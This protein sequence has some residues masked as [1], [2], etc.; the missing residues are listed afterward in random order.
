M[1]KS[2]VY[3]EGVFLGLRPRSTPKGLGGTLKASVVYGF[4]GNAGVGAAQAGFDID[5][6]ICEADGFGAW[7]V[8]RN[9]HLLPGDFSITVSDPAQW[10]PAEGV[11]LQIGTPPCAAFASVNFGIR[12]S[13]HGI[14]SGHNDC[15]R[16][17]FGYA[18]R[19]EGSDGR[20]GPEVI[21][22]ESVPK[23]YTHG[24]PLMDELIRRLR[25]ET[26]QA[27]VVQHVRLT[28]A[29]I[30][31]AQLRKRYWLTA[32]R[33]GPLGFAP[34]KSEYVTVKERIGD[35]ND[36]PVGII[37]DHDL[38]TCG[39]KTCGICRDGLWPY[40]EPGR[41]TRFAL[42]RYVEE[43]GAPPVGFE[44]AWERTQ[45]GSFVGWPARLHPDKSSPTLTGYCIAETAHYEQRRHITAREGLRL[46]GMP[47]D[48]TLG[49]TPA[50]SQLVIGKAAPVESCYYVA[51]AAARRLAGH[52]NAGR[53]VGESTGAAGEYEVVVSG[54]TPR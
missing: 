29:V 36:Q 16:R 8:E 2:D 45:R 19:S 23:A 41:N 52:D 18:A 43:H 34:T 22:M 21:A 5:E 7:A 27:Y 44:R 48:W 12:S 26:G 20:R 33:I 39:V 25:R 42:I 15:M 31:S 4:G 46:M 35:L 24:R 28:N 51:E 32:S 3:I 10:A 50:K 47:D 40:L 49:E 9:K 53:L 54:L 1:P 37:A 14:A 6:W 17:F 38:H 13:T 30:G 11:G